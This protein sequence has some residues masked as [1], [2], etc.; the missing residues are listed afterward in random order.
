[1]RITE[2]MSNSFF[3]PQSVERLGISNS[4]KAVSELTTHS[5]MTSQH[6]KSTI[7]QSMPRKASLLTA[8]SFRLLHYHGPPSV[9][10][11][12]LLEFAA[13]ST[14]LTPGTA[15][16]TICRASAMM[17]HVTSVFFDSG[18]LT[19]L[20]VGDL[21]TSYVAPGSVLLS[22]VH[23]QHSSKSYVS[24]RSREKRK[25]L[26]SPPDLGRSTPFVGDGNCRTVIVTKQLLQYQGED[27]QT[28]S[29]HVLDVYGPSEDKSAQSHGSVKCRKTALKTTPESDFEPPVKSGVQPSRQDA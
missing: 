28:C 13:P 12:A 20:S 5:S 19:K 2:L 15:G 9:L 14:T 27:P 22:L 25:F 3:E 1:M 16:G 11:H 7:L 29:N 8:D 26:S 10:R 18:R 23:R 17:Q 6:A 24:P 4:I 21:S